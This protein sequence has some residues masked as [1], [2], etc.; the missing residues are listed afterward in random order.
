MVYP[1]ADRK[2]RSMLN[3]KTTSCSRFFFC[4]L[5]ICICSGIAAK[6]GSG[7]EYKNIGVVEFIDILKKEKETP[8]ID[9]RD[10]SSYAPLHLDGSINIPQTEMRRRRHRFARKSPVVICETGLK[11]SQTSLMLVNNGF[12]NVRNV[13]GGMSGL[14]QFIAENE[15][16]EPE[17]VEFLRERM[18]VKTPIVG[19]YPPEIELQ[20]LQGNRMNP[21]IY[22]SKK[23][24]VLLFWIPR[25]ERSLQALKEMHEITTG[26]E[27]IEFIPVFAG[28]GR[29]E[30]DEAAELI[31]NVT[32]GRSLHTDPDRMAVAAL[33]VQEMP[34]LI[35]IDKKGILRASGIADVHQKLP[36]FWE[37]SFSDLLKM[38]VSGKETP[39]PENR[40]YGNQRTPMDLE[41]RSAPDFT[42]TD[43]EG[44]QHSLRDYRSTNVVLVFWAYFCPYS[45]KQILLL[46]DYYRERKGDIKV[47]SIA[48]RP[49]PE[50]WRKFQRF[51]SESNLS[52]PVLFDDDSGN[53]SRAYFIS[54]TPVWMV[55]DENGLVKAPNLGYS[56]QMGTIIDEII[57][58]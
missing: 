31:E 2:G 15:S 47:L 27:E 38:V 37:N 44:K 36:Y 17:A 41:G 14:I 5:I 34:A 52:F 21:A 35:L 12:E 1:P 13:Q 11:S 3:W 39:Y 10:R 46:D 23:T 32:P 49:Q 40:L 53:V 29:S 16:N 28:K 8:V 33:G 58:R 4:I 57:G 30:L 45:R 26:N 56:V 20:D 6:D 22:E 54:S 18:V 7:S 43:G 9:V 48:R 55:I 25:H 50:L 19:F 51:I 42:L 24:V